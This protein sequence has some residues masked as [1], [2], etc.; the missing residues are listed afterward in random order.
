M[1][2]RVW[3][4]E[5]D[6]NRNAQKLEICKKNGCEGN[7]IYSYWSDHALLIVARL[8]KYQKKPQ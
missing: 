5:P 1:P 4:T 3:R 6:K 2:Q 8:E 7:T